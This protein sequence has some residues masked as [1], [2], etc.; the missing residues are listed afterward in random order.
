M[1]VT[2]KPTKKTSLNG[3]KKTT[4]KKVTNSAKKGVAIAFAD[5]DLGDTMHTLSWKNAKLNKPK[6]A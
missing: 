2:K 4:T 5:D 1:T 3:A 6:Y